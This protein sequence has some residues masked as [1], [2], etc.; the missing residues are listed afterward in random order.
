MGILLPVGIALYLFYPLLVRQYVYPFAEY[1]LLKSFMIN[2]IETL[3]KFELPQWNEYVG[4]GHPALYFGHYGISLNTPFYLLFGYSDFTYYFTK[5]IGLTVLLISFI[6]VCQYLKCNY[7]TSLLGALVYFSVNF[8]I[9][10]IPAETVGYLFFLYP[11]LMVLIVKIVDENNVKDILLFSLVYIFWMAGGNITYVPMHC[12]MLS[13]AYVAAIYSF[14]GSEALKAAN[15]KKFAITYVFILI[16]PWIAVLYQYYFMLDVITSSNRLREGLVV[17]PFDPTVWRQFLVSFTSSSYFLVGLCLSIVYIALRLLAVRYGAIKSGE[18]K[19]RLGSGLLVFLFLSGIIVFLAARVERGPVNGNIVANGEFES[20]PAGWALRNAKASVGLVDQRTSLQI[21]AEQD[22]PGYVSTAIPTAVGRKYRFMFYF[23]K[24]TSPSGEIKMGATENDPTPYY[25]ETISKD[26]WNRYE[27]AFTANSVTTYITLANLAS[28]KGQTAFFDSIEVYKTD[29][30]L[31]EDCKK[32]IYS[33]LIDYVPL[34]KSRVFLVSLLLYVAIC[35]IQIGK[36]GFVVSM[37]PL[38]LFGL[39]SVAVINISLLSYYFYSPENIV[40]DV[41]GYDYDLFRELSV[42]SQGIF[43][44]AVLF[45]IK[46]YQASKVVKSVVLSAIVLYFIRSHFTIP[47]MRFTGIVWYAT[48][49]GSIFSYYFAVLFMFGFKRMLYDITY[50]FKFKGGMVV[51]QIGN[52]LIAMTLLLFVRDSFDKFYKGTS[53]RFIYPNTPE[54][55][56]SSME[57]WVLN[58]RAGSAQLRQKMVELNSGERK[59]YRI[60]SPENSYLFLTGSLQNHKIH[61]AAIYESSISTELN[62]F[63]HYTILGKNPVSDRMLKNVLP[64]FLFTKHVHAGLDLPHKEIAY[65]DFF[66]FHPGKDAE[67]LRS[68][69]IEFLWDLMQVKYLVI[70]PEFSR[71]VEGFPSH[72]NYKLIE[73][74]QKLNMNLYEITKNKSYSKLAILPLGESE[75]FNEVIDRLNSKDVDI[76]KQM[77]MQL[78]F[79]EPDRF[80]FS[81]LEKS[82]GKRSYK[83]FSGQRAILIDFES[84]NRNWGLQINGKDESLKKAFQMFRGIELKPGNNEILLTYNLRYFKELFA[85]SVIMMLAYMVLLVMAIRSEKSNNL[86]MNQP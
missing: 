31:L 47:L 83:I 29:L 77:Y 69:N 74:F 57:Q 38:S 42:V 84:W 9:R 21:E 12:V 78:E 52:G 67:Y 7:F 58:G 32:I 55:A 43:T 75:N 6:K 11:V 17:S 61:E 62:N 5:F 51:R 49:D 80:D 30:T 22:A 73:K 35:S 18:I 3:R 63:Y 36:K 10:I 28:V 68:Q 14:H 25:S 50:M 13:V 19:V 71:E 53:H 40:G 39:V 76:L 45:S 64:Y 1:E 26:G 44:L 41:N 81:F 23:K 56:K 37:S 8:V 66:M 2:F 86:R 20:N 54:L 72:E 16:V 27:G 4:S 60:F 70:G 15:L 33:L 34:L 65:R 24:G 48:R 46:D 59:F 82:S 79:L 85:L